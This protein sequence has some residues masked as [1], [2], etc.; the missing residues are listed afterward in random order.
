MDENF[1]IA[2]LKYYNK[3]STTTWGRKEIQQEEQGQKQGQKQGQGAEREGYP[4]Q[5]QILQKKKPWRLFQRYGQE[6]QE[7]QEQGQG[8]RQV[9]FKVF[10]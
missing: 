1:M 2:N 6:A 9:R 5:E 10:H 8:G 7:V 4:R 3:A